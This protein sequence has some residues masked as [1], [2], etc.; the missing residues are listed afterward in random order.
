[1]GFVIAALFA[2]SF[3]AVPF[4]QISHFT[5]MPGDLGDSRL[6]NYFLENIYQFIRGNSPS[7]IDLNFFYP[8]PSVSG[9]SDNLFGAAPAYLIPRMLTGQSD[10]ALQIWYLIG[11]FANFISAFYALRKLNVSAL[12]A[13]LGALI[14][15][16]ALPVSA[17]K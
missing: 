12:A 10:T 15:T 8:F 13:C 9:F 16:F 11:F 6:N 14:F 7:L 2:I 4:N 5:M 1:M 17:Q 3:L